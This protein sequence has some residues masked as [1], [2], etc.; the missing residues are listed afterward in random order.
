MG[1]NFYAKHI[2]T[3]SEYNQMEEALANRKVEDLKALLK[4]IDEDQTYHIGKRSYGW[5]FLF[6]SKPWEPNLQSIKDF[7]NRPDI[8]IYDEY[9]KK[10]TVDQFWNE[11][12]GESL[13]NNPEKYINGAQYDEEYPSIMASSSYEFTSKDGLRFSKTS[14]FR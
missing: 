9:G 10:F 5:Q 7:L 1:T 13:Y 6:E 11:E 2:I 14:D 3:E 8:E 12:V 4:V